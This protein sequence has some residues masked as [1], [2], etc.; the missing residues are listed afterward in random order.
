MDH[1]GRRYEISQITAWAKFIEAI[2]PGRFRGSAADV[3]GTGRPKLDNAALDYDSEQG[4]PP[5]DK[6]TLASSARTPG[7]RAGA[8]IDSGGSEAG[9]IQGRRRFQ[10]AD[11]GRVGGRGPFRS[12]DDRL[13]D[14][15]GERLS[16]PLFC[17]LTRA[18]ASRLSQ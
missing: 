9:R 11:S 12:R 14:G 15:V 6:I 1:A 2:K 17:F 18:S 7:V 4:F 8:V 5:A 13:Y 3:P 10:G 16:R